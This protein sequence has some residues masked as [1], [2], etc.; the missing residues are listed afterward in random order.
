M[1]VLI[2]GAVGLIFAINFSK[3]WVE[4]F[5]IQTASK[6]GLSAKFNSENCAE[7]A[8]LKLRNDLSYS[9]DETLSLP[10]GSCYIRPI[11]T[12]SEGN[13][14]IETKGVMDNY[15]KKLRI[16]I[17]TTSPSFEIKSWEF[18]PDF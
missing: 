14:E 1:T 10:E 17:G 12:T 3:E 18:V 5:R 4:S 15:Q 9:G 6:K 7:E 13:Y 11:A 8:L 16:L 2:V